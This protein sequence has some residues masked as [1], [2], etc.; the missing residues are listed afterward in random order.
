MS[1]QLTITS[2]YHLKKHTS[3][4]GQVASLGE[5]AEA[6]AARPRG[7]PKDVGR[8]Q[9]VGDLGRET[10]GGD[11]WNKDLFLEIQMYSFCIISLFSQSLRINI[12]TD[13]YFQMDMM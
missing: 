13:K 5:A 9:A 2:Y 12:I 8:Q 1:H 11:L 3:D 6:L 4:T 10:A 7:W